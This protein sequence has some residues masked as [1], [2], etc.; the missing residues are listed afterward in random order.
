M[1]YQCSLAREDYTISLTFGAATS[2]RVDCGSAA[3]LNNLDPFTWMGAVYPTTLTDT[4]KIST[5]GGN[6]RWE[7]SGTAGNIRLR[8]AQATTAADYTTN[9]TPLATLNKWYFIAVSYNSAGAAGQMINIYTGDWATAMSEATYGVAT[10]GVGAVTSD[11]ADILMIGNNAGGTL[12]FQGRIGHFS[13]YNVEL[14]LAQIEAQRLRQFAAAN[15]RM[16]HQLGFDGTGTQ[17]DKSGNANN[18]TVT[19]AT[20]SAH[21]PYLPPRKTIYVP[22]LGMFSTY[23]RG[24]RGVR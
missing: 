4:R 8:V 19:G 24:M 21:H 18:G 16:F 2:D 10:D 23:G 22:H 5:K 1:F 14:T 7:I 3:T 20:V 17:L 9:T 12:A 13:V 6:K 15:C 11:A